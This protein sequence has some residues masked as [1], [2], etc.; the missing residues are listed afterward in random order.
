M[1]QFTLAYET[2][3]IILSACKGRPQ[4]RESPS[5]EAHEGTTASDCC[6]GI[7]GRGE[8]TDGESKGEEERMMT[9]ITETE[10]A[11]TLLVELGGRPG[12]RFSSWDCCRPGLLSMHGG[13][14]GQI[15]S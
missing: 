6:E 4:R 7:E 13:D 3:R 2:K 9:G 11:Q 1:A 10:I 15:E 12:R 14:N 5:G 8:S